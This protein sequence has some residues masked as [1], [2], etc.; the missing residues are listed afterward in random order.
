VYW[1]LS[2][3]VS[4]REAAQ[5]FIMSCS[6][7]DKLIK[8]NRKKIVTKKARVLNMEER[9]EMRSW[10]WFLAVWGKRPEDAVVGNSGSQKS[11]KL[12]A[13]EPVETTTTNVKLKIKVNNNNGS[14]RKENEMDVDEETGSS[15]EEEN[16]DNDG[17]HR[18]AGS[19]SDAGDDEE[20]NDDDHHSRASS[21]SSSDEEDE[22]EEDKDREGWWGFYEPLEILKLAEWISMKAGLDDENKESNAPAATTVPLSVSSNSIHPQPQHKFQDALQQQ[23]SRASSSTITLNGGTPSLANSSSSPHLN[24]ISVGGTYVD[25]HHLSTTANGG[26][27]KSS[28]DTSV[29]TVVDSYTQPSSLIPTRGGGGDERVRLKILVEE[30]RA[31]AVLLDWRCRE[32]KYEGVLKDLEAAAGGA[33][34]S[35]SSVV[36]SRS[37]SIVDG[38]TAGKGKAKAK[39][40]D[41]EEVKD[42][43][44]DDYDHHE[45]S[46]SGDESGSGSGSEDG[47]SE[48]GWNSPEDEDV[49]MA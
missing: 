27:K 44:K 29:T 5:D 20:R 23:R 39:E 7:D 24:G 13:A 31:F 48:S 6:S 16:D 33:H 36:G 34:N 15:S 49:S 28:R 32:D 1:I 18:G 45:K 25:Q 2:P 9:V 14:A 40:M 17:G 4:E 21:S 47:P 37:G 3:G 35:G 30:L 11:L 41:V 26:A 12:K 22:E 43:E 38:G 19:Q 46:D 8:S 42:E 10:S